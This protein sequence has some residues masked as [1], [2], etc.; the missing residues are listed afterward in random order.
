MNTL[1]YNG[2]YLT[3]GLAAVL[4]LATALFLASLGRPRAGLLLAALTLLLVGAVSIGAL[5]ILERASTSGGGAPAPDPVPARNPRKAP[6][7]GLHGISLALTILGAALVLL[8]TAVW[9]I[10]F[11]RFDQRDQRRNGPR[12]QLRRTPV[13][14]RGPGR[15]ERSG[16]DPTAARW[17]HTPLPSPRRHADDGAAGDRDFLGDLLADRWPP[18]DAPSWL[19]AGA[20]PS[21]EGGDFS[22][23]DIPRDDTAGAHEATDCD[24]GSAEHQAADA[25]WEEPPFA[26]PP[27]DCWQ[28]REDPFVEN[29]TARLERVTGLYFK[30]VTPQ[31]GRSPQLDAHAPDAR[32]FVCALIMTL[33]LFGGREPAGRV[34]SLVAAVRETERRWDLVGTRAGLG[35]LGRPASGPVAGPEIPGGH[36]GA[37]RPAPRRHRIRVPSRPVPPPT[38][39]NTDGGGEPRPAPRRRQPGEHPPRQHPPRS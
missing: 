7:E 31:P 36:A 18:D 30:A 13:G 19:P 26:A 32:Y 24:F 28:A 4:G 21:G 20:A 35:A 25:A 14:S 37:T 39:D 10:W 2:V 29:L 27:R 9:A 5:L 15:A 6:V 33:D 17:T 38:P 16:P 8:G 34:E 1:V 22:R 23:Y 3:I 12:W 11:R